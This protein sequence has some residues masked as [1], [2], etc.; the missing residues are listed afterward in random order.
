MHCFG[1]EQRAISGGN[2]IRDF[3]RA[4]DHF[5]MT[6]SR[7]FVTIDH[8]ADMRVLVCSRTEGIVRQE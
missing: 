8:A 3:Y 4:L 6:I 7:F 2:A 1:V 5:A